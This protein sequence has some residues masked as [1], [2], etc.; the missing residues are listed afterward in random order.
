MWAHMDAYIV[1]TVSMFMRCDKP[2]AFDAER[3]SS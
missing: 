2:G 3:N 1:P